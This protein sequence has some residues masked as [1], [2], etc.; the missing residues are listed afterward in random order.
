[1]VRGS[2]LSRKKNAKDGAAFVLPMAAINQQI[3]YIVKIQSQSLR[4]LNCAQGRLSRT[5]REK[6]GIQPTSRKVGEKWGT[7]RGPRDTRSSV[8]NLPK[9]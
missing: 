7:R 1:M 4:P 3:I 9:T 6:A 5:K 2:H 8:C